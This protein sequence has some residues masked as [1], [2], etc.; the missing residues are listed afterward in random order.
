MS[1]LFFKFFY[2]SSFFTYMIEKACLNDVIRSQVQ[3]QKAQEKVQCWKEFIFTPKNTKSPWN[4]RTF[5]LG[6]KIV[7]PLWVAPAQL[8]PNDTRRRVGRGFGGKSNGRKGK[9]KTEAIASGQRVDKVGLKIK[10]RHFAQK[11][12]FSKPSPWGEGG[13]LHSKK[14][15]EVSEIWV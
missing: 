9:K 12:D 7:A 4:S 1:I 3:I 10:L 6:C 11:V 2:L 15:D 14:T 8:E 5:V 13:F